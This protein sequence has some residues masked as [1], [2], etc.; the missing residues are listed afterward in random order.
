MAKSMVACTL[1]FNALPKLEDRMRK[2]ASQIVRRTAH[3]I[4]AKAKATLVEGYG[5]DTGALKNSIYTVTH[6]E[7]NYSQNMAKARDRYR[8]KHS[9]PFPGLDEVEGQEEFEAAVAV[10]AAYGAYVEL[11]TYKQAA[12]PYLVPAA[13]VTRPVFEAAMK[14]LLD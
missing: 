4:E 10:G 11:G 3:D 1:A 9:E 12:K 5:V 13:E 8:T 6:A 2:K 7:S 14:K